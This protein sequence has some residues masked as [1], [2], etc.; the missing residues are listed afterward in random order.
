MN[1]VGGGRF[2]PNGTA[3]RAMV[4]T[5]LWRMEGKPSADAPAPFK[6]LEPGA[7]YADAVA[8]AAES[9]VVKGIT[10]TEFA[11]DAPMTREQ[12]AAILYRCAQAKGQGFTGMWYFPLDFKDAAEVS[13]WADEAMH[14]MVMKG[15]IKGRTETT[16][17]PKNQSSRAEIATILMRYFTAIGAE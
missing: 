4:V 2:A 8:W 1:G 6:D 7:W 15:I 5:M 3:T 14:W 9:G 13:D 10:Q 11:P 12:L 16:L 17:N